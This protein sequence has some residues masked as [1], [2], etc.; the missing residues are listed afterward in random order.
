MKIAVAIPSHDNVPF[1]FAYDLAGLCAYTSAMLPEG[2]Q[3]GIQGVAGTYVHAARNELMEEVL[4]QGVDWVLWLDSD[5]RFPK[6]ALVHLLQAGCDVVGI[7]YSKRAL[8][9]GFTALK[10][11]GVGDAGEK[12]ETTPESTGLEEVE[13]VGFGMVLMRTSC[14]RNM[15]DPKVTP[16]FQ[17]V[18]L[19][20]GHWMGEDVHFCKLLRETGVR[21]FVDHDLSKL[22]AHVGQMEYTIEHATLGRE[23][24]A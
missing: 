9:E 22:C 17:N 4:R 2:L 7:N 11:V 19:G 20:G 16:W 3:F 18:Y 21:I 15:P 10:K 12:L 6:Q 13:A 8:G 23:V 14:L 5:M 1:L 24:A